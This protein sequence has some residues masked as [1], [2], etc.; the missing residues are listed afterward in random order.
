M[1]D[2][3]RG[4]LSAGHAYHCWNVRDRWRSMS[5]LPLIST[6][7]RSLTTKTAIVLALLPSFIW[8]WNESLPARILPI[9]QYLSSAYL[10]DDASLFSSRNP[11]TLS[12]SS[13]IFG[14]TCPPC[15]TRAHSFSVIRL[16]QP[17]CVRSL[18]L[19]VS[20]HAEKS[21]VLTPIDSRGS[22]SFASDQR[23]REPAC[24]LTNFPSRIVLFRKKA[25]TSEGS[26]RIH[27]TSLTPLDVSPARSY[28]RRNCKTIE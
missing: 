21:P 27:H 15:E 11:H 18:A 2:G 9:I 16:T 3:H 14:H 4:N 10:S 6:V 19:I 17:G 5:L 24:L 23:E 13:R 20:V 8:Q 25:R 12:L 26:K 1:V 28:A 22:R 7:I